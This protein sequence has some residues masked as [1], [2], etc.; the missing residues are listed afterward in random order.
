MPHQLFGGNF[1]GI[2]R[3][4]NADN[5][6]NVIRYKNCSIPLGATFYLHLPVLT[7]ILECIIFTS[8]HHPSPDTPLIASQPPQAMRI[9]QQTGGS[10][11]LS[12]DVVLRQ[13]NGLDGLTRK[14]YFTGMLCNR[15]LPQSTTITAPRGEKARSVGPSNC[16][17]FVPNFPSLEMNRPCLS[18]T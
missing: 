8:Q 10:R 2:I 1:G 14:S 13:G 3:K 12:W 18:N 17:G 4:T 11:A 6:L 7:S 16:P 9:S 15:W 5:L